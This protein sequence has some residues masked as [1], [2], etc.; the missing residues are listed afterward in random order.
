MIAAFAELNLVGFV[1][2]ATSPRLGLSAKDT[3][4]TSTPCTKYVLNLAQLLVL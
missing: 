4:K 1:S 2:Y 3:S